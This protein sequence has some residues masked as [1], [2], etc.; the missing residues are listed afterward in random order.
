MR[1][2][3][4]SPGSPSSA[5]RPSAAAPHVLIAR[6]P[7]GQK[8]AFPAGAGTALPISASAISAPDPAASSAAKSLS[9]ADVTRIVT[10]GGL[11]W[12]RQR[13]RTDG[14]TTP[15]CGRAANQDRYM[16]ASKSRRGAVS[17]A[18]ADADPVLAPVRPGRAV[19]PAAGRGSGTAGR[20]PAADQDGPRPDGQHSCQVMPAG[21]GRS[22]GPRRVNCGINPMTSGA[23]AVSMPE[24][25]GRFGAEWCPTRARECRH[26]LLRR[27]RR[28]TEV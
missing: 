25:A 18:A 17:P 13:S 8:A 12:S 23:S 20:R 16:Q 9:Q 15:A 24:V 26:S 14:R 27:R 4:C 11:C 28:G 22:F 19:R 7:G 21:N 5:Q 1:R 2:P 3:W 10:V 6:G